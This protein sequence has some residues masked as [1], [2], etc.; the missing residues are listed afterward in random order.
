MSFPSVAARKCIESCDSAGMV[1]MQDAGDG[2]FPSTSCV[3]STGELGAT[4]VLPKN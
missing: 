1:V 3:T 4:L 2:K